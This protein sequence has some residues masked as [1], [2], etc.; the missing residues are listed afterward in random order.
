MIGNAA[1]DVVYYCW[2]CHFL[3]SNTMVAILGLEIMKVWQI[4]HGCH[5]CTLFCKNTDCW[6]ILWGRGMKMKPWRCC[7][8]SFCNSRRV[9]EHWLLFPFQVGIVLMSILCHIW[10]I[11][12][13]LY[14][15]IT[16]ITNS[17]NEAANFTQQHLQNCSVRDPVSDVSSDAFGLVEGR[18]FLS[19]SLS[20]EVSL[21]KCLLHF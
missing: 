5:G 14:E 3:E 16:R 6:C 21:I 7:L 12:P 10:K 15:A 11:V 4:Q 19:A 2:L 17:E 1:T 9:R 8:Q 13:D 20:L 18:V